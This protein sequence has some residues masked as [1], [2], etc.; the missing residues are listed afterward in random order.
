MVWFDFR[1]IYSEISNDIR[2]NVIFM[3]TEWGMGY[4]EALKHCTRSSKLY[5]K[6]MHQNSWNSTYLL[7]AP[8]N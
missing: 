1:H 7:S 3:F 4:N 5:N 8:S 2:G 6:H